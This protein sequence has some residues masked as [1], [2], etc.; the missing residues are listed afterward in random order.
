MMTVTRITRV[1]YDTSLWQALV[2]TLDLTVF[3]M[4]LQGGRTVLQVWK[5]RN[6]EVK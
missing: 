2:S 4:A 5:L 3:T 1:T 6:R